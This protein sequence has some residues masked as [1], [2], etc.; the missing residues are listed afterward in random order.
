MQHRDDLRREPWRFALESV[1]NGV[2]AS[3][4]MVVDHRGSVPG[5]TGVVA[6]VSEQEL[7]GTVGG[8][9]AEKAM[10]DRARAHDGPPALVPF[11][12]VPDEGGTL[13]SGEQR[14]VVLR[15]SQDDEPQLTAIVETLD[16]HS[17]GTLH[18]S[19]DGP[20]FE[21]GVATGHRFHDDGRSWWYSGPVG[22]LDTVTVIGGGHVSLALSRILATLPFRIVVLDNRA[23]L[24]TMTVNAHAH[25]LRVVDYGRIA[26]AVPEGD[27]SWVVIMTF[28]H[29]HDRRVLEQ[30][31]GRRYAYL[32]LMGSRAKVAR[33][34]ADMRSD[35][36]PDAHLAGVSAPVG[37]AIG[38]HTPEE[39][40]ISIA[41]ELVARRN[42]VEV[43]CPQ[44]SGSG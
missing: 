42:G 17:A 18:L 4:V 31:V 14:F 3:L 5:V 1:R 24:P 38:S 43:P 36:V 26:E 28:G 16:A 8:G 19:A 29:E 15:L 2:P 33:M 20:R 25:E 10:V 21:P 39:I 23:D 30:L 40:A 11:R 27:R 35:G 41:A 44:P 32:G 37:V 34:F 22:L 13:C 6:V 9:V 12:H 7:A